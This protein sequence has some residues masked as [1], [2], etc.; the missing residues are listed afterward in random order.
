M[1]D[2]IER[3][4]RPRP[5]LLHETS[6]GTQEP[7]EDQCHDDGVVELAGDGHE[8]RHKIDRHDE[9][10]DRRGYEPLVSPRHSWVAH[11][12]AE[13]DDAVRHEPG[14]RTC[15]LTAAAP[16]GTEA[17]RGG[18]PDER[19]H[20]RGVHH[21]EDQ[22]RVQQPLSHDK[23]TLAGGTAGLGATLA[24]GFGQPVGVSG[25]SC[26]HR[27]TLW[28]TKKGDWMRA[29]KVVTAVAVAC[30]AV[31]L[32][33]AAAPASDF[34][35]AACHGDVTTGMV[36]PPATVGQS[37]SVEFTLKEPGDACPTFKVSSGG[38]P[39]G[40][41]LAS[42]DGVARGTPT[43]PGSFTFFVTVSYTCGIGGKGPGIYSDQQYTI[44]V[45]GGT[46]PQPKPTG[47]NPSLPGATHQ[48]C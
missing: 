14:Q 34:A 25:P 45:N 47:A 5:Q 18:A 36:C 19:E 40:L 16:D 9:R 37:Y 8:V 26:R 44:N 42:D 12:A 30:F 39:P 46:P 10:T 28:S 24:R 17:A 22:R 3:C 13:Q 15:V 43:Q 35:D 20:E 33:A 7:S 29:L 6:I 23:P 38:L 21:D 1:Q 41:S 48:P 32:A 2:H 11:Q 4:P 27:A 31:L